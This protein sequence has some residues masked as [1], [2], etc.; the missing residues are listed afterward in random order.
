[1]EW[2]L[3]LLGEIESK[4]LPPPQLKQ[5]PDLLGGAVSGT[6]ERQVAGRAKRVSQAAPPRYPRLH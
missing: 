6:P 5:F 1:M 3:L 2:S 4:E